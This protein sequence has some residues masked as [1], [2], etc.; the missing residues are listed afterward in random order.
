MTELNGRTRFQEQLLEAVEARRPAPID[1]QAIEHSPFEATLE[2]LI[3]VI[4]AMSSANMTQEASD[5][6]ADRIAAALMINGLVPVPEGT[7]AP[8]PLPDRMTFGETEY[9]QT[10]LVAK[11]LVDARRNLEHWRQ[12]VGK[13]QARCASNADH[14]RLANENREAA[15]RTVRALNDRITALEAADRDHLA[16]KNGMESRHH[17]EIERLTRSFAKIR[18]A[19][20]AARDFHQ[21]DSKMFA[22]I[23]EALRELAGDR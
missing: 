17:E 6:Q 22:V 19:L 13:L 3:K 11:E 23:D 8:L 16:A 10:A 4:R 21:H 18:Y 20:E 7:A 9:V 1:R 12:E 2:R 14:A 15:M 5:T